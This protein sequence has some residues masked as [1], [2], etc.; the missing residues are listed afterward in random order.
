MVIDVSSTTLTGLEIEPEVL[1]TLGK[2]CSI[3]LYSQ[4]LLSF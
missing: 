3:E 2:S 1:H 4:L